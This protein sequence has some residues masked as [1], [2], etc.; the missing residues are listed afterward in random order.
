MPKRHRTAQTS[1]RV[2]GLAMDVVKKA[3]T[4]TLPAY[5]RTLPLPDTFAGFLQLSSTQ[6]AQLAPLL[7]TLFVVVSAQQ[8]G[9]GSSMLARPAVVAECGG[10][11]TVL[12]HFASPT[13]SL[14]RLAA[15]AA[16]EGTV[17]R[18]RLAPGAA[19]PVLGLSPALSQRS[20]EHDRQA[21]RVQGGGL[22][23]RAL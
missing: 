15:A 10:G 16:G 8:R 14:Q 5:L 12:A 4:R 3:L 11:T 18:S 6:W 17:R 23:V 7:A 20:R 9:E 19:S 2:P 21:R 13:R 1:L 22:R